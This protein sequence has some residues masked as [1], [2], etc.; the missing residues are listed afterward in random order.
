MLV[1]NQESN[2]KIS[3]CVRACVCV[4]VCVCVNDQVASGAVS[5]P[6]LVFNSRSL[7]RMQAVYMQ[8]QLTRQDP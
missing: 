7:E 8:E 2:I 1:L 5:P 6:S 3:A 4:C